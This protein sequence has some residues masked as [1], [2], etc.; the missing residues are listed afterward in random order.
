M[1]HAE[2]LRRHR[3]VL[4]SWLTLYYQEPI[5]LVDGHGCRAVDAEGTSYLDFFGGILTTMV[6]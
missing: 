4:P 2:L 6:G 1:T 5:A 3:A